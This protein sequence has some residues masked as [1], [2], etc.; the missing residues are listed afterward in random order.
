M[1]GLV[2]PNSGQSEAVVEECRTWELLVL[3]C[4]M[5]PDCHEINIHIWKD[6]S[7]AETC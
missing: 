2:T 6:I 4:K 5:S 7:H 1:S 3:G